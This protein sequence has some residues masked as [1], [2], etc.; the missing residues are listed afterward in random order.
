MIREEDK[1]AWFRFKIQL[2]VIIS[3]ALVCAYFSMEGV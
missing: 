2:S 1:Q 3:L